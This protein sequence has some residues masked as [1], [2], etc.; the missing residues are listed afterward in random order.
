MSNSDDSSRK[1]LQR[2]SSIDLQN[3]RA[4]LSAC[5]IGGESAVDDVYDAGIRPA[6]FARPA[7]RLVWE[8][9]SRLRESRGAVDL[10]TVSD[11]LASHGQL[12]AVG[13]TDALDDI[14]G[15]AST[16]AIAGP[17]AK[18]VLE[19]A[20]LRRIAQLA[21]VF[22]TAA[23]ARTKG[24]T[25]LLAEAQ[26]AFLALNKRAADEM[27]VVNRREVVERV[28]ARAGKS[29]DGALPTGFSDLDPML[30][31]GWRPGSLYVVA[32][33]PGMGKTAFGHQVAEHAADEGVPTALLSLE[34]TGEE[35]I[36]RE[37]ARR[38]RAPVETWGRRDEGARAAR[39]AAEVAERPLHIIDRAGM[40]IAAVCAR[41]RRLVHRDGVQLVVVDYIGL[42]NGSDRYKGD[43]TNEVGEV[44]K[45]LKEL[46]Q[47]LRVP[48]IALSQLNRDLE[49]RNDKRPQLSD[50]RDSG[51]VE[52][53]A[54]CVLFLYREEYYKKD[55][56]PDHLRRVCEVIVAKNRNGATGT[57]ELLYDGPTTRFAQMK[58]D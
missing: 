37:I 53:D 38:S 54:N 23:V 46:A 42:V 3:E 31:G 51:S 11:D 50:L 12:E 44:T 43:R 16:S 39:A 22:Q 27:G 48:V 15:V 14:E 2:A 5:L 30:R 21:H 41:A 25:D 8:A 9:I 52:Q 45:A 28:L 10:V 57:V 35:L 58:R 26:Q 18:L 6:D 24:A 47:N 20:N 32:A 36:E 34:M 1:S 17:Y 19:S 4:L 7:H 49:K 40:D 13:G 33:R 55:E 56:T 29:A